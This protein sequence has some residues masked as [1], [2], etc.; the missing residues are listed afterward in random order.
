MELNATACSCRM[1]LCFVPMSHCG[2]GLESENDIDQMLGSNCSSC[3]DKSYLMQYF[4]YEKSSFTICHYWWIGKT[5]KQTMLSMKRT[6]THLEQ[7]SSTVGKR[8]RSFLK[9][10]WNKTTKEEVF[11][12]KLKKK[13]TSRLIVVSPHQQVA[14]WS[15]LWK[16]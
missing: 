11:F 2:S 4:L 12:S 8:W 3:L 1:N 9:Q 6:L 7:Q 5:G 13:K 16:K 10:G 14:N 15:S